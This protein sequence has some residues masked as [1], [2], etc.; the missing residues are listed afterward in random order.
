MAE[1]EALSLA[2]TQSNIQLHLRMQQCGSCDMHSVHCVLA[3]MELGT[4]GSDIITPRV[5]VASYLRQIERSEHWRR[6]RDWSFCPYVCTWWLIIA[7]TSL[8]Q[9]HKQQHWLLLFPPSPA[10]KRLFLLPPLSLCLNHFTWRRYALS[11]VSSSWFLLRWPPFPKVN[12]DLAKSL[13]RGN[14]TELM[15]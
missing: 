6:L 3:A 7:M 15:A 5:I 1:V 13:L 8:H 12:R 4:A 14:V 9:Q 11:R 2:H 10:A